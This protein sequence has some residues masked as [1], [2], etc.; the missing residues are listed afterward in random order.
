MADDLEG[1]K[2]E[3]IAVCNFDSPPLTPP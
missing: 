1:Y 3:A 2:E